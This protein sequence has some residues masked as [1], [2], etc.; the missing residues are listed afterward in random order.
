VPRAVGAS[1]SW[2]VALFVPLVPSRLEGMVGHVSMS[3]QDL[4][5]EERHR[6]FVEVGK[7]SLP[8]E[9]A[10]DWRAAAGP[11][12][13]SA[14]DLDGVG[15]AGEAL[16]AEQDWSA[17]WAGALPSAMQRRPKQTKTCCACQGNRGTSP[18]RT[19]ARV[20]GVWPS[21]SAM[22]RTVVC[23]TGACAHTSSIPRA[24]S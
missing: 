13:L 2:P 5:D 14:R 20:T 6:L 7:V 16:R 9:D 4:V 18:G 17:V 1:L 19:L 24:T 11:E 15:A 21:V 22:A 23:P 12:T 3:N 10:R 8:R